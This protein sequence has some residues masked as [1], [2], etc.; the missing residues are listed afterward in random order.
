LS[1]HITFT[2][3][4]DNSQSTI[5][6]EGKMPKWLLFGVL[7]CAGL[8]PACA[9]AWWDEGHMQVAAVAYDR[10]TPPV[11][12]KVDALIKLNPQYESWVAGWP[13]AKVAQYAFVRAAT[14][15]DDIKVP[16]LG[17][18]DAGDSAT[19]PEADRNIGYY[20]TLM[21]K[22]WHFKDIGFSIDGTPLEDADPVNAA[23]QIKLLTAGLSPSSGL[24]DG[25]RSYDLVWLLHLVGDA[26]QPLHATTRFSRDHVHGDQGGNLSEVIPAT[27]ETITLHAYWDRLLGGSSTAEGAIADALISKGTALPEPDATLAS[28]ANPDDWFKESE[29]LAEEFAY[30]EPVKSGAQPYMLDR[31]YETNARNIARQQAALAGARLANLVNEALK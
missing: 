1:G 31:Q 6:A 8:S 2:I 30:A 27:G 9:L 12:A 22:Y 29:K 28:E 20:D 26:H 11:R 13:A 10:L 23:T 24:P 14:W 4:T 18:T 15:A 17:Y 5:L 7:C 16:T 25:V 19:K 21:H 3:T